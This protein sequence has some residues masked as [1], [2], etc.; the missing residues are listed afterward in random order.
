MGAER[1]D[2]ELT[3]L[4]LAA[5][6][7]DVVALAT[8]ARLTYK[9]VWRFC[10]YLD[11]T[12]TADDLTQDVYVRALRGLPAYRGE[13]SA[14]TWLLVIARRVVADA[15]RFSQ[16]RGRVQ[17]AQS[18]MSR[19][20]DAA[21]PAGMV[22]TLHLLNGLDADRRIAFVLTQVVGLSYA[23]AAEVCGCAVGTIRSRVARARSI[24]LE[25]HGR[26]EPSSA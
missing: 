12:A 19:P 11:G 14:R 9:D 7:G 4:A 26:V 10:A 3:E 20:S 23:E 18:L 24:L 22:E 8:F 5:R 25:A 17:Q 15:I 1:A 16:R 21:D 13:S 2:G 6:Q